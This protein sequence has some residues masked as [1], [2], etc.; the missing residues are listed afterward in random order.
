MWEYT[1]VLE[2]HRAY[3]MWLV[4][5]NNCDN[6]KHFFKFSE[7]QWVSKTVEGL[8]SV[9][10]ETIVNPTHMAVSPVVK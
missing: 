4:V 5:A 1:Y 8:I 9:C 7:Q 2:R 3:N 6:K 10:L